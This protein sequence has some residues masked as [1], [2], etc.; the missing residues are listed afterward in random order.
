MSEPIVI[1]P[2]RSEWRDEFFVMGGRILAAL[3]GAAIRIDHIGSTSVVGLDA[4]PVID[5]Q[6]SVQSFDSF[7]AIKNS[8]SHAGFIYR[9][10][11]PDLTKRYFR[12]G[13]GMGRTH[14]HVREHGSFSEQ[15]SL[16]F[17]DYLRE[18]DD[19]AKEY[20]R[21]KVELSEIYKENRER[22]VEGKD[23]YIWDILRRASRWS[24]LV[25]WKPSK[26][27]LY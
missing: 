10:D 27:D 20:A 16:L 12:E 24:Q 13:A 18:H 4:K 7:E 1:M 3:E 2:Y 5:I 25:G 6:V 26:P 9:A 22:Y 8:L 17:R 19:E 21:M 14:I 11:N 23:P 15:V